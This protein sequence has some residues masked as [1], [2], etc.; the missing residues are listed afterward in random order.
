[1]FRKNT[2]ATGPLLE[3]QDPTAREDRVVMMSE[4]GWLFQSPLTMDI[5]VADAWPF[6]AT[7]AAKLSA[8]R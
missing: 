3:S 2:I 7:K 4:S 8:A 1:M 5:A 6:M